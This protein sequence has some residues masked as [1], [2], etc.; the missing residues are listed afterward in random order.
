M[1]LYRFQMKAGDGSGE[2]RRGTIAVPSKDLVIAT[3]EEREQ[4]YV[5]YQL[6]DDEVEEIKRLE[7]EHQRVTQ[8]LRAHSILHR[9]DKPYKL[10]K[11]EEV[12]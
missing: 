4:E 12:K 6:P 9:Q 8:S 5:A 11:I 7:A 3:L 1:P 10:S 2:M